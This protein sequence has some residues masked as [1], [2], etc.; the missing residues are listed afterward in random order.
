M[1]EKRERNC[2]KGVKY[3]LRKHTQRETQYELGLKYL[4]LGHRV[5]FKRFFQ[6]RNSTPIKNKSIGG[7]TQNLIRYL[8]PDTTIGH[9]LWESPT[10]LKT[11]G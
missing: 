2:Q 10:Q 5:D 3:L 1:R 11:Q 4:L 7:L 6:C 8:R 9:R